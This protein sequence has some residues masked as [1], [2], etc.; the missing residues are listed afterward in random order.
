QWSARVDHRFNANDSIYASYEF[1]DSSEFYALSNPLCSARDVPGWGC[2]ELQRTQHA[3]AVW[4]H[5]FSPRLVNEAR[6]GYTRFGFYRLQEDRNVN[7]IQALGI[8]GL[9]DAGH[10]SIMERRK[11]SLPDMRRSVV[12]PTCRRDGTITPIT[13]S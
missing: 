4:T 3:V 11:F 9:T 5:I 12:L 6:A 10:R 1:A 8:A 2:D 13:T 7:V